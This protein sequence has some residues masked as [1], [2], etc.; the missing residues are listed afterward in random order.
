MGELFK[1][2]IYV[3]CALTSAAC[4][5]MLLRGYARSK[6]RFLLWS[7]L[8]FIALAINNL[9]LLIDRVFVTERVVFPPEWRSAVA[10]VGLSMLVLG[11][12][13]D[14]E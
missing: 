14:A 8:C 2:S 7:S 3:L 1:V 10:L 13:W 5:F 6:A 12:V 4:A 9:M 11:L